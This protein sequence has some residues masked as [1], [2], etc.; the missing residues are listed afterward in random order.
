MPIQTHTFPNGFRIIYDTPE[1][2]T[3][4][5]NVNVLCRVGSAS[6]SETLRGVSHFI[7]HMCFKGTPSLPTARDILVEYDTIGAYFNAYTE[8]QYTC[9]VAKFHSDYTKHS[10]AILSDILL[11]SYFNKKEYDK[12]MNVVIEE[13]VRNQTDYD[14]EAHDLIESMVYK[15]SVY[16]HPI[17]TLQYHNKSN[18]WKYADVISFYRKNYVP[19]NMVLSIVSTI[20]FKR[21]VQ[22]VKEMHFAKYDSRKTVIEPILNTVPQMIYDKQ[23]GLQVKLKHIPDIQTAYVIVSFRTCNL[24]SDDRYALN[25]LRA[26]L[27]ATFTSRMFTILREKNGLTYTSRVLTK[28]Y[29]N[30]GDIRF[31]AITDS[32]KLLYNKTSKTRHTQKKHGKDPVDRR[33]KGVLQL[34]MGIIRDLIRRGVSEKELSETKQYLHGK[35]LLNIE[36]AETQVDYNGK[37]LFLHNTPEIVP[38]CSVYEKHIAPI[39]CEDIRR[40]I[41]R[42][43]KSENMNVAIVGG[44][45]ASE[46]AIRKISEL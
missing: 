6:E 24:Y 20:P 31:V 37:Q 42:Y 34:I 39:T 17:D 21:I 3:N 4:I 8:K 41:A 7:E 15:G 25:V 14:N 44:K 22:Y 11:H 45:L 26:I 28:Y 10:L 36:N 30:A 19:Q 12:E 38:Y 13:N 32:A 2:D 9:Y 29:E 46:S 23:H 16:E 1:N 18:A 43:F 5:T 35:Q 27:G 33:K 40:V